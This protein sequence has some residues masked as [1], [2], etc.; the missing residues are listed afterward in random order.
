MTRFGPTTDETTTEEF[1]SWYVDRHFSWG[2]QV[3]R[4][5]LKVRHERFSLNLAAYAMNVQDEIFFDPFVGTFGQDIN[6]A[7]VRH[8]GIEVSGSVRP[9]DWLE[10][11]GSYT[12]DATKFARDKVTFLEGNRIPITPRH[13][14]TARA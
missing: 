9:C 14:G 13:R 1:T 3:D 6:I 11:Y 4:F 8:R 2:F 7:R 12:Y 5:G 10:L